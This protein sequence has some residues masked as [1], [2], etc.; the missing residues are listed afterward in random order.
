MIN[1]KSL[2][3]MVLVVAFGIVF[4]DILGGVMGE[5]MAFICIMF[6]WGILFVCA[7]V[8]DDEKSSEASLAKILFNAAILLIAVSI[9]IKEVFNSS[10]AVWLLIIG[11]IG[12]IGAA[13]YEKVRGR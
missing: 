2:S 10:V 7:L 3:M 1:P 9:I 6:G 8:E 5:W 11:F 4:R 12:V 13:I